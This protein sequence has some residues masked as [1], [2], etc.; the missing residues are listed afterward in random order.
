MTESAALFPETFFYLLM[1]PWV[2][3]HCSSFP[4]FL[5]HICVDVITSDISDSFLCG[6]MTPAIMSGGPGF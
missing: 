4:F 6:V 1:N 5:E 3:Q 2:Q